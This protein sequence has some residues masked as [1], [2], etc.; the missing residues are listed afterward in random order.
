M[1]ALTL[2]LLVIFSLAVADVPYDP[3]E[4]LNITQMIQRRGY[5]VEQHYVTT[6][7][8]FRLSIQRI[9]RPGAPVVFLLHGFLDEATT[10]IINGPSQSLGYILYDSGFDIWLGNN[11]GNELSMPVPSWNFTW[12]QMAKYDMPAFHSYVLDVT[13][14]QGLIHV[15]HSEG[16][17][18]A[19]AGF[20]INSTL[21]AHVKLFIALA[22]VAHLSHQTSLMVTAL[23]AVPEGILT[24]ILGPDAVPPQQLEITRVIIEY[25]IPGFCQG[26]PVFCDSFIFAIAGCDSRRHCDTSNLN[27]S[28]VPVY[29]AHLGGSSLR[30]LFHLLQLARDPGMHMFDFGSASANQKVYGTP[31]PPNYNLSSVTVPLAIFTGSQDAF[32]DP[33]DVALLKQLLPRAPVFEHNEPTYTH[34][35]PIWGMDA[36]QKIYPLIV[37]L[38]RK[39]NDMS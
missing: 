2:L 25:F 13:K 22:P 12:D 32:A 38:A 1:G 36:H 26:V 20:S 7:D 8:G 6:Q 10:W 33:A 19:F 29:S 16:T 9:P 15:G 21:Q 28:R 34:L 11:R 27:A 37:D 5:P 18:E 30:N 4:V 24:D 31:T 23:S 14:Q 39:Y 17:L 3:D 35:D